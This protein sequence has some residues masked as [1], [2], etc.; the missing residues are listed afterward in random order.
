MA[1]IEYTEAQQAEFCSLAQEIGIGRAMT[2]LGFPKSYPTG[3]KWMSSR[4]IK[5]N[6]DSLM[7]QAKMYH[8]LYQAEDLMEQVDNALFVVQKL[9]LNCDNADDAKKLA[10]ALQKLN[11]T[12]LLLEGKSTQITEKRETTQ[13]DLEIAEMIRMQKAA[14]A[15]K[16]EEVTVQ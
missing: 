8:V 5:P 1:N 2:E 9:M 7:Q 15:S 14:N 4:G 10:E 13:Q 16:R 3:I 6:V 12:R 11:N